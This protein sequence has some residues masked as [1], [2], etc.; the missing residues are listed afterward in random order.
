MKRLLAVLLCLMLVLLPVFSAC[1]NKSSQNGDVE[2]TGEVNVEVADTSE[3]DFTFSD[4]DK[5]AEYSESDATKLVFSDSGSTVTGSGATADGSNVTVSAAGTYIVSGSASDACLTVDISKEEKVQIVLNGL[6]LSS[7]GGPAILIKTADKVFITLAEGSE[8]SLSDGESYELS[9][10][11]TTVD[12]ALFSKEDLTI[13][14]NGSLTVNGN[15][16]HGIVSKDDTVITGGNISVTAKNVG[17]YGKDCV[18]LG[19]GAVTVNAGTDGVRSDNTEDTSRGYIYIENTMLS[20]TSEKDGIQ[21]ETV[22][23]LTSGTVTLLCGGGSVNASTNSDGSFNG[24]WRPGSSSSSSS[25]NEESAKGLKATSDIIIEGGTVSADTADDCIHSNNTVVISAGTLSLTSGDDGI[26][27][28]NDLGISGGKIDVTKSYEGI[29]ATNIVIGGGNISVIASD[30]GINAAG[31]NDSSGLGG[32]PGMGSFSGTSGS[33]S[34]TGGY[35]LINSVGDGLD[36][37]GALNV[38]GGVTLVNGPTDNGNCAFDHDGT[39]TAT[40]GVLIAVGS[41]GMAETFNVAENQGAVY[42]SFST[43]SAGSSIA[44]CDSDGNV[45]AAFTPSKAYQSVVMTAPEIQKGNKYSLVCGGTV[46]GADAN[47]FARS[48]TLTGG[49]TV[50]SFTMSSLTYGSSSGMGGGFGGGGKPMRP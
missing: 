3:M 42:L 50:T 23:K 15:Y 48:T 31:G 24:M 33:I 32:R 38:S 41:S 45:I 46:S 17:I 5:S 10:D 27:A 13:N 39:A 28:D 20:I 11:D 16:K 9:V 47:G 29:E 43:Q 35:I 36:S 34:I 25:S 12:A 18:K 7:K 4:K 21:A 40:G 30:D 6:T 14:G 44:L 1:G 26:H 37:N 2:M 22:L 19:G 8:N 49:T